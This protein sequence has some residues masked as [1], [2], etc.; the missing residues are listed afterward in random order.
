M[1]TSRPVTSVLALAAAASAGGC[2]DAMWRAADARTADVTEVAGIVNAPGGR[3]LV[4]RYQPSTADE[5]DTL[6]I[7]LDPAGRPAPPFGLPANAA[8]VW[9]A[10]TADQLGAIRDRVAVG[11]TPADPPGPLTPAADAAV[12]R[13]LAY[14]HVTCIPT[15]W[16]DRVVCVALAYRVDAAGVVTVVPFDGP[17]DRPR[18]PAGADVVI[19]PCELPRPPAVRAAAQDRARRLTPLTVAADVPLYA[20]LVVGVVVVSP[21]TLIL[22]FTGH[23]PRC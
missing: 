16:G 1:T 13:R 18:V 22:Y 17:P 5:R 23:G 7:P 14:G 9:A 4:V 21:L 15:P 12:D 20:A 19:V 11:L 10:V 8:D 3:L 2:T 6:S